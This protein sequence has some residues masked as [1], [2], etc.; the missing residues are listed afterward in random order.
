MPP[1]TSVQGI[2]AGFYRHHSKSKG[3][4]SSPWLRV[5]RISFNGILRRLDALR[6]RRGHRLGPAHC[7][8]V[9]P[10]P[11][12]E[13]RNAGDLRP[14]PSWT[15]CFGGA[16]VFKGPLTAVDLNIRNVKSWLNLPQR[17]SAEGVYMSHRWGD[18]DTPAAL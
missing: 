15:F 16:R 6:C 11:L 9:T 7:Q 13:D 4:R 1:C 5:S 10:R 17:A 12:A 3:K 8:P 14:T 2:A 18:I